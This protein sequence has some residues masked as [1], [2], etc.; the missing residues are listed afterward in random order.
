[1]KR[2]ETNEIML[3]NQDQLQLHICESPTYFT[4]GK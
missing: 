1:M 4:K 3:T 2:N